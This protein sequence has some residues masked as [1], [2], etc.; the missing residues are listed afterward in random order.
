MDLRQHF[1]KLH[2]T[3]FVMPNPWDVGSARLLASLGFPALAT[4]SAGFAHS[5]GRLDGA[6]TRD[7]AL[8]HARQIAG[9]TPLP[10]SADFENGFA[11]VPDQVA[12]SVV[13]A[14]QTGLAGCSI[15]DYGPEAGLYP[16][17]LAVD[18]VRAAVEASRKDASPLVLTAR[19]EN[20]LR[21]KPDLADTIARLQAYQEAGA[22]VL[23]APALRALDEVKS[24][25]A[26]VDRPLNVLILPGGPSVPELFA[27]GVRRISTGSALALAANHA[28]LEAGR[29]LLGPGTHGFWSRAF[30]SMPT[31]KAALAPQ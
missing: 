2:Q 29:E 27:A 23:Y 18:R 10:V 3:P 28:L 24:V 22:E 21:G 31:V 20:F 8:A 9:A 12:E 4:T 14:G 7:E 13:L 16:R 26:E 11:D 19:C 6:V 30:P 25:L 17:E 15:E 5:L 1:R